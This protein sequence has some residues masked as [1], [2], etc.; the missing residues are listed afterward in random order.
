ML[1]NSYESERTWSRGNGGHAA[2]SRVLPT[3]KNA[4]GSRVP[5]LYRGICPL[6]CRTPGIGVAP[7][8]HRFKEVA[9]IARYRVTTELCR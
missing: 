6:S 9:P 1:N 2:T 7:V 4:A 3:L 8:P 5:V